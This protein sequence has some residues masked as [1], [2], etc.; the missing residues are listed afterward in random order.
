MRKLA[1]VVFALAALAL[2]SA[3]LAH[4][5]G[6]FSVNR[7]S[8]IELSGERVYVHYVL[9]LAEIP[10]FQ[11]G[12]QVR[13]PGFPARVG[14]NLA[15]ELGGQRVN[16]VPVEHKLREREGV[17][18]L[19]TLR[20]EAVYEAPAVAGTLVF[21]DNN[22][23]GRAGWKEIVVRAGEGARITSSSAPRASVSGALRAYPKD[24]LQSPP[25]V[26]SAR[27]AFEPGSGPGVRPTLEAA[28]GARP[29][30]SGFAALVTRDLGVGVVLVS[31]L[32]AMFW[33]AAHALT[34]GHGKAVVAAYLVGSRGTVRHALLLGGI[35]TVTHT[36]GVF[37]LGLVTLSLSEFVVPERLYPWLNLVA[38]LLVVAVGVGVLRARVLDRLR[39]RRAHHHH[40]HHHHEGHGHGHDHNHHVPGGGLRGLVAVGVS[41]G[42]LPCPTA[43]VVLLAAVSLHRVGYGLLLIVAFSIGLA[44]TISGIGVLAVTAKRVFGRLTFQGQ[45]V[46]LL[47]AVSALVVVALGIAMAVRAVPTVA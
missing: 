45:L 32:L 10:A 30:T 34:P 22:F 24:L 43:L 42:L 3:A 14:K 41:G 46:R 38:A 13:G 12:A 19:P 27:V 33:G 7:F 40:H 20:F 31:L 11:E 35:V 18:G 23:E 28:E 26:S 39:P 5:L 44:A 37:A 36:I 16:L 29:S 8:G 25:D 2:P 17:G 15:L 21:H 9:D 4:P 47:P 1:L 6:N